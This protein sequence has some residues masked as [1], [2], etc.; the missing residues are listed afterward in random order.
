MRIPETD[1][2]FDIEQIKNMVDVFIENGFTYF[3]TA[4]GYCDGKSELALKEC[5]TSRYPRDTYTVADKLSNGHFEKNEDIRP[6]FEKELEAVGVDYFDYYLMHAQDRNS[7]DKYK[8]CRAYE[9]AFELKNEGKI[10]H[11]GLSFH[12]TADVLDRIL[13]EYPALEFVQ[14]QFNYLDFEDP[15]VQ[16]RKCYET[17][18]KHGKPVVVMEPVKGGK[19]ANVPDEAKPVFEALGKT[20]ANCA[21]RFA[22]GFDNVVMVLSGMSDLKM[23]QENCEFMKDFVPLSE[24]E[25]AAINTVKDIYAKQHTIPCTA[26]KY[27]MENCPM[28]IAIPGIFACLNRKEE[29][30]DEK[31]GEYYETAVSGKGKASDCIECGCCEASCPQHIEIRSLLKKAAEEFEK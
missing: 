12:D 27:C 17:C 10:K 26:C 1:G 28:G 19:L 5:L 24:E 29:S 20:P 6:L 11:V 14:L 22:A 31:V 8:K 7:F 9:T 30:K 4:H 21:I 13:T 16:S 25:K 3:D 23:T 2:V 15:S 18:V